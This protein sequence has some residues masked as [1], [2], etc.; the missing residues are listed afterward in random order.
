MWINVH[1]CDMYQEVHNHVGRNCILCGVYNLQLDKKD[2]PLSFFKANTY[3]DNVAAILPIAN[4][5]DE[6]L[7]A[8]E[9]D[10]LLFAPTQFH[11]APSAREKHGGHRITITFNVRSSH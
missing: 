8:A 6:D 3:L 2:R 4:V 1:T 5:L 7:D 10:L 9:G 11:R